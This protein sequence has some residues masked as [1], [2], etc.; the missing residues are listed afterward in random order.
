MSKK[1][2]PRS[3]T[4]KTVSAAASPATPAASATPGTPAV[5]A[6]RTARL[7]AWWRST[8]LANRIAIAVPLATTAIAGVISVVV[9]VVPA[10]T[11]DDDILGLVDVA[12]HDLEPGTNTADVDVKVR[13]KGDEVGYIKGVEIEIL[14][15]RRI[16]G[17]TA[18]MPV[19]VTATY[20][21][22]LPAEPEDLPYTRRF[23]LDHEVAPGK[24]DRFVLRLGTEGAG[25]NIV[26][27]T[28][29]RFRLIIPYNEGSASRMESEP[30]LAF[31]KYPYENSL[32]S[33]GG[34]T[35]CVK[36][37]ARDLADMAATDGVR[38]A[39]FDTFVTEYVTAAAKPAT[40]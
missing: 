19:P 20:D 38:S 1:Q 15:S 21:I 36:R 35:E 34:A 3:G 26:G 7:A 13:S 11:S 37:N 16:D 30:L 10:L 24:V 14:D 18:P 31:V 39:A 28:V 2:K 8:T 25:P 33:P 22:A 9:A 5:S 12:V 40:Q 6:S 17:C 27:A 29:Y 4:P 32:G 23:A